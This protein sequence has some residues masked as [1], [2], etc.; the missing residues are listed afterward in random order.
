MAYDNEILENIMK[1]D[2]Y[3]ICRLTEALYILKSENVDLY[4][5]LLFINIVVLKET[6]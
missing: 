6:C 3:E 4:L 1:M 2:Q 5:K